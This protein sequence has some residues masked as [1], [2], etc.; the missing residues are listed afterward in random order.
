MAFFKTIELQEIQKEKLI[1]EEPTEELEE[2]EEKPA[3]P[4]PRLTPDRTYNY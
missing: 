1:E 4:D 2:E 3:K